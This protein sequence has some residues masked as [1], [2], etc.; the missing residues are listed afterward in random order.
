MAITKRQFNYLSTMGITVWQ[1]H[2]DC[3]PDLKQQQKIKTQSPE[4]LSTAKTAALSDSIKPGNSPPLAPKQTK[5]ERLATSNSD[6]NSIE[7]LALTADMPLIN[8]LTLAIP[9]K[10]DDIVLSGNV[11]TNQQKS[12]QIIFSTTHKTCTKST[13]IIQCPAVDVVQKSARLKQQLWG[14][15]VETII[16]L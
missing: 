15:L 2:A 10:P 13:N 11:M 6:K 1:S 4:P 5:A 8:D 14:L 7:E 3:F 12:W 16:Q 9:G